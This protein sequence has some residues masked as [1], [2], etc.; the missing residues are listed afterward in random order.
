LGDG[1]DVEGHQVQGPQR[2]QVDVPECNAA[3][4]DACGVAETGPGGSMGSNQRVRI[5]IVTV[6]DRASRGE[7]QDL[8]GPAIRQCLTEILSC[9]WESAPRLIPDE[10]PTLEQTLSELCD[11]EHCCLIVTTA[12]T[13]LPYGDVTPE[14]TSA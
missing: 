4:G 13:C 8:G 7:Y 14:A 6:S 11:H 10:Q 1:S 9:E 12:A 2:G 5:G 3:S